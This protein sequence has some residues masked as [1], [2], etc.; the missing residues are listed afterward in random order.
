MVPAIHRQRAAPTARACS[1]SKDSTRL[2]PWT[3]PSASATCPT[4]RSGIRHSSTT[5]VADSCSVPRAGTAVL[6]TLAETRRRQNGARRRS[7]APHSRRSG[8][9]TDWMIC[10]RRRLATAPLPGIRRCRSAPTASQSTTRSPRYASR[11]RLWQATTAL[12]HASA[13]TGTYT[14]RCAGRRTHDI[15]RTQSD[16]AEARAS[17]FRGRPA[18]PSRGQPASRLGQHAIA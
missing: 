12:A 10:A 1:P 17:A 16:I 15:G 18:T 9:A 6:R 13:A 5:S 14:G 2:C 8:A 11:R 4:R 7:V 3:V